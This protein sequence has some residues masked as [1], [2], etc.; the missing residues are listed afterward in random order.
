MIIKTRQGVKWHNKPP[1]NGRAFVAEDAANNL[2]QIAAKLDPENAAQYHSRSTLIGMDRAEAIDDSTVKVTFEHP[3]SPFLAGVSNY[4]SQF[5]PPELEDAGGDWT[6]GAS[7]IGT[8]PFI[9]EEFQN[10]VKITFAANPDYW[11]PG[12]PALDGQET[13]WVPDN[14][15]AVTS[16]AQG[17][18]HTL[19]TLS[20]PDRETLQ[21]LDPD[22][23]EERWV[24]SL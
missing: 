6:D 2:M 8:G 7:L 17:D 12:E 9:I 4:R 10:D 14:T 18:I 22:V 3:T 20:R 1:I 15:T 19:G 24:H 16:L 21:K 5:A 11:V 23:R 13:V